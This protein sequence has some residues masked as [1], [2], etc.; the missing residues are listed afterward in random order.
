MLKLDI[1]TPLADLIAKGMA[2]VFR[3]RRD[4]NFLWCVEDGGRGVCSSDVHQLV[5]KPASAAQM[6]LL[7]S[8]EA[9]EL[10]KFT[11][12]QAESSYVIKIDIGAGISTRDSAG[13]EKSFL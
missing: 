12:L 4:R 11:K 9:P 7:T 2:K 8:H 13:T 5:Q 6:Q 1:I 3:W 10:T